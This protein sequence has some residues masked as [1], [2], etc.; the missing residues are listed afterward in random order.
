MVLRLPAL[1]VSPNLEVNMGVATS[2]PAPV[3]VPPGRYLFAFGDSY[4]ATLFNTSD[5]QPSLSNPMGNPAYPGTTTSGADNWIDVV[6][7]NSTRN[8]TVAYNY[9]TGANMVNITACQG[10]AY[11]A[12]GPVK[13]LN[14]Q[15]ALFKQLPTTVKWNATNSVFF[16][17]FGIND[18]S[19]QVYSGRSYTNATIILAPDIDNYFSQMGAQYSM[20]ARR[21]VTI[22]VPPIY[23]AAVHGF[24]NG[25][26]A[27]LVRN[28]TAYWN[29][30]V[31]SCA[32]SFSSKYP[33]S[34]MEV[35]DP[36]TTFN[37]ILDNPTGYGAPNSTCYSYPAG[38][39]CLWADFIHPGIVM[40]RAFGNAMNAFLDSNGL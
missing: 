28:L 6:V 8:D 22:L 30:A 17:F 3:P 18:I 34:E 14:D 33:G 21:F 13:E 32:K 5:T 19:V 20:G 23:R 10:Q 9:A 11:A 26:A 7:Y 27:P 24:G 40:Q 25:T 37:T 38:Q 29:N 12:S 15:M 39:P 4:T 31:H 2:T 1:F 35:F 16:N 36:S